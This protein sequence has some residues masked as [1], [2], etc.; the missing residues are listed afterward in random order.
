MVVQFFKRVDYSLLKNYRPISLLSHDYKLFLRIVTNRL[1]TRLDVFEQAGFRNGYSFVYKVHTVQQI[2]QKKLKSIISFFFF[3]SCVWNL[4]I[5]KAFGSIET[6][7]VLDSLQ[8]MS[9]LSGN[10]GGNLVISTVDISRY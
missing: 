2:I 7:A 1:T 9:G 3:F 6:W 4:W 8:R 10:F 5:T